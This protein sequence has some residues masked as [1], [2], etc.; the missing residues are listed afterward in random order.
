MHLKNIKESTSLSSFVYMQLVV[1]AIVIGMVVGVVDTIFGRTL[2]WLGEVRSQYFSYLIP[3]L[4]LAGLLIVYLYQRFGGKANQGMDLVFKVGYEEENEIPK[5][6][7]PLV[8]LTTWLTHLFGGSAGREGVAVQIGATV[9]N[10]FN[11]FS[12]FPNASRLFLVMGMAAGFGGLFQTPMAAV[13]FAAEVLVV[14]RLALT[15]IAPVVVASFT[16]AWTSHGLGLEKFAVP[17]KKSLDMT[18]ESFVKLVILGLCFGLCGNL[19]AYLLGKGKKWA[20]KQFE[21]PYWRIGILGLVASVLFLALHLGRY[22]GLGTNLISA[23]F[24]GGQ[25]YSYDWLLKLLLTVITLSAGYQGGEVTPL[26][27][28][29][30]SLGVALSGLIGLPMELVAALGY[31]SVFGSAT[32][33][34]LAPIFIG[35][36]VFG[37][38]NTPAFFIVCG[39]AYALNRQNSIYG[40]QKVELS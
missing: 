21:N 15:A 17:I 9:G 22:T 10:W 13:F 20:A 24:T 27:A 12:D 8:M 28:M 26:F 14:G 34:F 33:T 5:R 32:N 2:L 38:A 4:G 39:I 37:F 3:F 7:I 18:P 35:G 29:G 23:S 40:G 25:I 36:E 16:S 6:L 19:F 11:R 1:S 31:A 30:A